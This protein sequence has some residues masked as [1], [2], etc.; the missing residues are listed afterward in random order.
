MTARPP[1]WWRRS[2][3]SA[4]ESLDDIILRMFPSIEWLIHKQLQLPAFTEF[5]WHVN[6]LQYFWAIV[7]VPEGLIDDWVKSNSL[8]G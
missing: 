4:F 1:N 2:A 5:L 8:N 6:G 7:T 3:S